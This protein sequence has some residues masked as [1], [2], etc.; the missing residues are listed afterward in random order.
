MIYIYRLHCG[1]CILCVCVH[2]HTCGWSVCILSLYYLVLTLY[3]GWWLLTGNTPS[4]SKKSIKQRFLKLLSCCAPSAT[5]SVSQCK[6][7]TTASLIPLQI[8]PQYNFTIM[9]PIHTAGLFTWWYT[10]R[11]NS[12]RKH[13]VTKYIQTYIV[14]IELIEYE[15]RMMF[16]CPLGNKWDLGLKMMKRQTV[17]ELLR[18][19]W[20]WSDCL[21]DGVGEPDT[22]VTIRFRASWILFRSVL[23]IIWTKFQ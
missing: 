15:V 12:W 23:R 1:A 6:W 8:I 9:S 13:S 14:G 16:T 19:A 21:E 18:R 4:Q 5:P 3:Y 17:F 22:Y 2:A 11:R 10:Q 20:F 7:F